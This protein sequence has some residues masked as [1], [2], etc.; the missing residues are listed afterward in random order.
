ELVAVVSHEL[1]NPLNNMIGFAELLRG[2]DALEGT[3]AS[4][5]DII[6]EEGRR[7]AALLDDFLDLQRI[8]RAAGIIRP[9]EVDLGG[10][11]ARLVTR[12]T[13]DERHQL[14]LSVA[15]ELPS[16]SADPERVWQ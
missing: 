13:M 8:D 11:L 10:L 7:L 6:V 5:V 15:P 2:R 1:R 3:D 14:T 4:Y 9:Q 12:V 16:V